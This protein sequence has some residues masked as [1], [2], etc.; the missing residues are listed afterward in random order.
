MRRLI[1]ASL[2]FIGIVPISALLLLYFLWA[3]HMYTVGISPDTRT[4]LILMA[5]ADLAC[6][7]SGTYLLASSRKISN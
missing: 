6:L 7:G 5:V 4:E 1:G 3:R 2:L